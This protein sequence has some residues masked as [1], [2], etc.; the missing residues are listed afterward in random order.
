MGWVALEDLVDEFEVGFV[1]FEGDGGVVVGGVAVLL[2]AG[3]SVWSRSHGYVAA[4][5]YLLPRGSRCGL[6][7]CCSG[8]GRIEA[9]SSAVELSK[10]LATLFAALTIRSWTPCW[11]PWVVV[12]GASEGV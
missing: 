8:R 3:V 1:E 5:V 7:V 2:V 12:L 9:G 11:L 4:V 10:Q 6:R